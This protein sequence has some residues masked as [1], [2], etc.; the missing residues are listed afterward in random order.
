[1]FCDRP[2]QGCEAFVVMIDDQN[3]CLFRCTRLCY[4]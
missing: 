4:V 2:A 1:V 3:A